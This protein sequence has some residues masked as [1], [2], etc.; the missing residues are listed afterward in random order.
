MLHIIFYIHFFKL[1]KKLYLKRQSE[2]SELLPDTS[3]LV[4]ILML[5]TAS[6]QRFFFKMQKLFQKQV[7]SYNTYFQSN[8]KIRDVIN[9]WR[10]A[11]DVGTL[12]YS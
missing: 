9:L 10:G 6:D 12:S 2:H 8:F 3:N 11:W 4:I 7:L 5:K 1:L